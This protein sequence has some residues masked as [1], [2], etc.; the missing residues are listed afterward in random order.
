MAILDLDQAS[1]CDSLEVFLTLLENEIC[2]RYCP[3]FGD[4][5]ER[6]GTF[7]RKIEVVCSTESKIGEELDISN[8]VGAELEI[9]SRH[10]MGRCSL[11]RSE[12]I[13]L[14]RSRQ[15]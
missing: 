5:G 13:E 9:T 8:V 4:L 12:I 14:D 6:Y 1:E 10:A 3:S 2:S 15:P 11:E 7:S